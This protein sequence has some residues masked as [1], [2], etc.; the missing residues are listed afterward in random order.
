VPVP[1]FFV[2]FVLLPLLELWLLIKVGGIIGGW[3]TLLWVIAAGMLGVA[4]LKRQGLAMLWG[5]NRKVQSGEMQVAELAQGVLLALAGVLLLVPGL[6]TDGLGFI[7]LSPHVRRLCATWL[8]RRMSMHVLQVQGFSYQQRSSQ[9]DS[10][11][12]H[13]R[14]QSDLREQDIIEGEY[15]EIDEDRNLPKQ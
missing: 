6:I 1:I 2:L 12:Q 11:R 9:Q 10:S 13:G 14:H 8:L 4:V 15:H 5:V 3:L 7:L